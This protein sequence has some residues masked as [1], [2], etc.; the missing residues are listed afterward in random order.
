M[1]TAMFVCLLNSL[2]IIFKNKQVKKVI[3]A[4]TL[5]AKIIQPIRRRRIFRTYRDR[6]KKLNTCGL[7]QYIDIF[8]L[9]IFDSL[10]IASFN[11]IYNI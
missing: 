7:S 9:Y 5:M 8:I 1:C 2:A 6:F 3:D 11:Q 10:F 4:V